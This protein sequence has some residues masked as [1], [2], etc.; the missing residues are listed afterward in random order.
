MTMRLEAV[1]AATDSFGLP[2]Q[3]RVAARDPGKTDG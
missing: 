3:N 2:A 1:I